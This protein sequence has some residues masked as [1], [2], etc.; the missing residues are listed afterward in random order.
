M[1]KWT[2]SITNFKF[3]ITDTKLS[4]M[5]KKKFN[6]Y[7]NLSSLKKMKI[8]SSCNFA[9]NLYFMKYWCV[10]SY[11]HNILFMFETSF[12]AKSIYSILYLSTFLI[13]IFLGSCPHVPL[14]N[15]LCNITLICRYFSK[16]DFL[17]VM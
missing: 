14:A 12:C 3:C 15:C 10:P 9:N 2:F 13:E 4:E 11:F 17:L 5:P 7:L 1:R 6:S 8:F 16:N